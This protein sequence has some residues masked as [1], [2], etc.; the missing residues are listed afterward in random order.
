VGTFGITGGVYG[1]FIPPSG[2]PPILSP[3]GSLVGSHFPLLLTGT[4][5]INYTIQVSTD[6]SAKTWANITTNSPAN[7]PFN[8][9]DYQATNVSRFYRA[10]AQ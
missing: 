5:G 4:P 3:A 10:V 2:R 1:G 8:F 7:G 6:L 9:I